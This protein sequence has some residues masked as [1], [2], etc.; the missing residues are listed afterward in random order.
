[1]VNAES[2]SLGS[3]IDESLVRRLLR[4]QF[5]QW[6]DLP[7]QRIENG[8]WCNITFRLGDDKIVRLPRH[9]HYAPQVE[10]ECA[11]LPKLVPNLPLEI[12]TPLAL[13]R[14]SDSFPWP[15]AVYRWIEGETATPEHIDDPLKFARDLAQFLHALQSVDT[16]GA[17]LAGPH[18]FHRGGSL[19]VY[20]D[21]VERAITILANHIDTSLVAD[22][23]Q[24]AIQTKWARNPVW[25]HGDVSVGNLLVRNGQ[26]TAVI[27]FG[28]M[29]IGDPACD[30]VM[31]WTVF[32]GTS[33]NAFRGALNTDD[34]TW[35]RG[36]AWAL[37]KALIL[38][39]KLN[40]SNAYEARDPWKVI[41][42]VL[43]DYVSE[44]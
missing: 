37:W 16:A 35:H 4:S 31:A 9:E 39:A 18:S 6:V 11:W 42:T 20:G 22:V 33:R 1:M 3:R 12:P 36:R 24:R 38:A 17:P 29:A 13:G 8:G 21:E 23:W 28:N 7:V 2:E 41:D 44:N 32:E 25:I 34:D 30:L 5:P 15:W 10:K 40:E 19:A 26:L 43:R 14:P 27:D